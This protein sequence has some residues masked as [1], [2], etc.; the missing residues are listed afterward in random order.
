M[1]RTLRSQHYTA[2]VDMAGIRIS[3]HLG[4]N[5]GAA[6]SAAGIVYTWGGIGVR[7]RED[8]VTATWMALLFPSKCR[9]TGCSQL[10]P[11]Y[12]C[13]AVT[14]QGEVFSLGYD[15]FGQCSYGDPI[16][17][18]PKQLLPRRVD[19]LTG[20]GARSALAGAY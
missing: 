4:E 3:S 14:E 20:I 10:S 6:V 11:G 1:V 2:A 17:V 13:L 9:G 8:S 7:S 19:A 5:F 18:D 15:S 12:A 16:D